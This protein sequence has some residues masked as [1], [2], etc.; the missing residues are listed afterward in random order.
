MVYIKK[1]GLVVN[2]I[3]SFSGFTFDSKNSFNFPMAV[4]LCNHRFTPADILSLPP[5][6]VCK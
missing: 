1:K 4:L 6:P 5:A 3:S 2:H